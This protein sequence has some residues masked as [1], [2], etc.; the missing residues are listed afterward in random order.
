MKE[1]GVNPIQLLKRVADVEDLFHE[2]VVDG[3]MRKCRVRLEGSGKFIRKGDE[4]GAED[5]LAGNALFELREFV[6]RDGADRSL[7]LIAQRSH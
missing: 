3:A 4:P 1:S 7:K 2:I 6:V 5:L